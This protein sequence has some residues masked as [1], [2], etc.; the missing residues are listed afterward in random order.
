VT[1]GGLTQLTQDHSLV[2]EQIAQGLI[3]AEDARTHPLR[4]VITRAVSGQSGLVV[5]TLDMVAH[6]GDRLLLCSDGIH[7]VL[8]DKQMSELV[9]VSDQALDE[10]CRAVIAAVNAH[11]GP[12][13]A[14][15]IIVQPD[16]SVKSL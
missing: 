6:P 15:L 5:D 12:D 7:G 8:T 3:A 9:S 13:N 1:S 4:H 16:T 11:G 14:T 2:A 10:A